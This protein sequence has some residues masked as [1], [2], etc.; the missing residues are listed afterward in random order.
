MLIVMFKDSDTG[1]QKTIEIF[2]VYKYDE[3]QMVK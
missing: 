3:H 2:K 1:L